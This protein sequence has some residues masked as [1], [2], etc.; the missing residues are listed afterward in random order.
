MPR[1]PSLPLCALDL[2]WPNSALDFSGT[3]RVESSDDLAAW[4]LIKRE[5]PVVNL[6][7]G[8]DQLMQNRI[9]FAP[10]K[11]KFWR[12]TW[13]GKSAPFELNSVTAD[14]E[15]GLHQPKR[16]SPAVA[17]TSTDDKRRE[18]SFDLSAHLPVRQIDSELGE[19]NSVTKLQILSCDRPSDSWRPITEA[20]FFRVHSGAS[21][22]R[23]DPI[24]VGT[25]FDRYLARSGHIARRRY[26]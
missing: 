6:R 19:L 13:V 18:V 3:Q 9:E 7:S 20:N 17:S 22:R 25:N 26:P 16:A 8:N 10:T 24:S 11:A 4:H 21:E 15:A 14:S 5:S 2:T 23:N 12:L 1:G